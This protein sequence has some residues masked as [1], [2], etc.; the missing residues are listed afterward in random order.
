LRRQRPTTTQLWLGE[1]FHPSKLLSLSSVSLT[2]SDPWRFQPRSSGLS[3]DSPSLLQP[4]PH[5]PE[6]LQ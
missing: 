4:W 2:M 6:Q 1:V 3:I 5:S